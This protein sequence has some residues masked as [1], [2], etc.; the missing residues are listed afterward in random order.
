LAPAASAKEPAAATWRNATVVGWLGEDVVVDATVEGPTPLD[1][2]LL[3]DV[4]SGSWSPLGPPFEGPASPVVTD[5]HTVLASVG[6]PDGSTKLVLTTGT[7]NRVDVSLA[8]VA[9]ERDWRFWGGLAPL[10]AGGYVL[11]R[12]TSL[13]RVAPDAV[14]TETALPSGWI[15]QAPTSDPEAFLLGRQ[16]DDGNAEARSIAATG[17]ALWRVGG[18]S[19]GETFAADAVSTSEE[20]LALLHDFD[21]WLVLDDQGLRAKGGRDAASIDPGGRFGAVTPTNEA[22]CPRPSLGPG[23]AVSILD[24]VTGDVMGTAPGPAWSSFVWHEGVVAYAVQSRDA[25]PQYAVVVVSDQPR[26]FSLPDR[27]VMDD[28]G[29]G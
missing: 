11:T 1:G 17:L 6:L 22:A 12:T 5:G 7:G 4:T 15:V 16:G 13:V 19:V 23:C 3:L 8:G 10:S 14:L 20:G 29:G 9:S 18:R 2:L 24:A 26:T 27:R 25:G 21:E 28:W